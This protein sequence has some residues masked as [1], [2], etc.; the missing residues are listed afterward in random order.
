M[1]FSSLRGIDEGQSGALLYRQ[2]STLDENRPY[3]YEDIHISTVH[4]RKHRFL[5][6]RECDCLNLLERVQSLPVLCLR[7]ATRLRHDTVVLYNRS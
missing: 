1:C 3:A 5:S 6:Q 4:R 2:L 7:S